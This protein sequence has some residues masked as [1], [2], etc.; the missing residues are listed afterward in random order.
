VIEQK[1]IETLRLAIGDLAKIGVK[2][3]ELIISE[4]GDQ[5]IGDYQSSPTDEK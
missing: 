5:R 3:L 4:V 1:E 2:I